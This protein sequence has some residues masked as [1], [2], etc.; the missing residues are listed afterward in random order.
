MMSASAGSMGMSA[1]MMG[2]SLLWILLVA[3][4]LIFLIMLLVR[5]TNRV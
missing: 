4:V 5:G 3:A 1:A 2:A